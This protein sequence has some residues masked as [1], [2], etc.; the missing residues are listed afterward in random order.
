MSQTTQFPTIIAA[1]FDD[2][3]NS[4]SS[5]G[6]GSVGWMTSYPFSG[7]LS[8]WL[9][10]NKEAAYMADASGA[11]NPYSLSNGVLG[12]TASAVPPGSNP[13]N[14]P[15]NGAVMTTYK[16]FTQTYGYFETRAQLPLGQGLWP[17]IWMLPSTDT[18]S[19]SSELDT[20]EQLGSNPF[21]FYSTTHSTATGT[22]VGNQLAFTVPDTTA[23]FHT[24][25]V[26]WEPATIT[27]Y[28][29]G[30]ALGSV[31]TPS[32]MTNPMYMLI[33]LT[34]GGQGSWPGP[35]LSG[36]TSATMQIDYVRAYATPATT[37][38][39]G[40][41]ALSASAAA[42]VPSP[43]FNVPPPGVTPG[44][45]PNSAQISGTVLHVGQGDPGT[46][47]AGVSVALVD[48]TG[49]T[50]KTTVTD[51]TGAFSFTGRAAGPYKLVYTAPAGEAVGPGGP[52]DPA[53]GATSSFLLG[54]GSIM[55]AGTA[56]VV[57]TSNAFTLGNKGVAVRGDGDY[58]VTGAG[59][60]ANLTLGNGNETVTLGGWSNLI[61]VGY[62]TSVIS[63]GLGYATVR[64]AGGNVTASSRGNANL[65]DVGPGTNVL[66]V[67]T[68]TVHNTFKLN[69][70]GQGVTTINGFGT[71]RYDTLGLARTLS[72]TP[73][74][75]DFSNIGSFITAATDSGGTTLYVDPAGGA[76]TPAAFAYLTNVST[77]VS[78]LVA[79]GIFSLS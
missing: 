16:S 78:Q 32:N 71:D 44:A 10:P 37:T 58:V 33:D 7:T 26:D 70:S 52:A 69:G 6:N 54:P 28:M 67:D 5:S 2:E 1:T 24:Y 19:A 11:Y 41:S 63:A 60:S 57:S 68:G 72:G 21:R 50:L 46:G 53:T 43:T 61:T 36:F 13:Y 39:S 38:V 73:A 42:S 34:V 22:N 66:T 15:Y 23:G 20:M 14:L 27:Y 45:D 4:F 51:N 56:F 79:K 40:N 49:R 8:R 64:S 48:G 12:I 47:Q 9:Y 17:A 65:F 3:F 76:G 29:D 31:P 55:N 74:S 25:G 75:P 35:P 18:G 30:Y 59:N 62:G 77:T